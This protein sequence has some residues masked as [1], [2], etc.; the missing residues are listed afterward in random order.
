MQAS[1]GVLHVAYGIIAN[2]VLRGCDSTRRW[3]KACRLL[4]GGLVSIVGVG[5]LALFSGVITVG[6]LE[7]LKTSREQRATV[8]GGVASATAQ[9]PAAAI[10]RETCPHCG[11]QLFLDLIEPGKS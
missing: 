11:H 5:T 2:V 3:C 1:F 9:A 10:S 6:F 4:L 7:Q 8:W